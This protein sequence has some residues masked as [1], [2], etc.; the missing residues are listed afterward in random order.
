M[1]SRIERSASCMLAEWP[2]RGSLR[3]NEQRL[4]F[5]ESLSGLVQSKINHD[6]LR[7][8]LQVNTIKSWYRDLDGMFA[9]R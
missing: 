4:T 2:R 5:L 8:L 3:S 7:Y 1:S 6:M 9:S